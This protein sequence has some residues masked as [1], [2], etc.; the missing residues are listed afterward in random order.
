MTNFIIWIIA[1]I[2]VLIAIGGIY[3]LYWRNKQL[4]KQSVSLNNP[5]IMT[6]QEASEKLGQSADYISKLYANSP[7][8]FPSGSIQYFNEQLLVT[9]D[10]VQV[11]ENM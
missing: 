7:N 6:A 11:L 1:N 4:T 9:V 3:H 2:V 5:S 8:I 10:A